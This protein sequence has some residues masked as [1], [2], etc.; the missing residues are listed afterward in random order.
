MSLDK[1]ISTPMAILIGSAIIA[2]GLFLG[3]QQ[4]SVGPPPAPTVPAAPPPKEQI[5][6]PKPAVVASRDEVTRQAANALA[7]Q[8]PEIVARCW[9]PS[10]AKQAQPASAKYVFN[11]TFSADGRQ[12]GRGVAEDRA[13][14][15]RDLT[16]CM[17]GMLEPL[18]IPPPGANTYVEIPLELP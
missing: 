14:A 13:T 7:G 10:V 16:A 3:L 8:R 18:S 15:R 1:H 17:V 11:Y 4:G 6:P 5:A 2:V 12:I 9:K